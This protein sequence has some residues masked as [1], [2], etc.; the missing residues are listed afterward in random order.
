MA[1]GQLR[2]VIKRDL[3]GVGPAESTILY[4]WKWYY[5]ALCSILWIAIIFVLVG[6]KSNRCG[7]AWLIFI[8]ILLLYLL[9]TI[10]KIIVGADSS[11]IQTFDVI[12]DGLIFGQAIMWLLAGK[13]GGKSFFLS[14]IVMVVTGAAAIV[15]SYGF[16]FSS[17]MLVACITMAFSSLAITAGQAIAG[18][19]CR[20]KYSIVKF[21]LFAAL[22]EIVIAVV[23]LLVFG[24][25]FVLASI[26]TLGVLEAIMI[27]AGIVF[28]AG[29][30]GAVVYGLSLPFLIL[31]QR[32]QFWRQRF[33]KLFNLSGPQPVIVPQAHDNP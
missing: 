25:I 5:S 21:T 24:V 4:D 12:F 20:R 29:F 15:S 31:V 2:L 27:M 19:M 9:W 28:A 7:Q 6:I 30:F 1:F 10:F 22:W 3:G 11:Q 13:I 32:N 17:E 23:S 8:P 14:F 33:M 16:G 18:R 26:S